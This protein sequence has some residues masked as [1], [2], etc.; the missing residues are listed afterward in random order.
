MCSHDRINVA[1]HCFVFI[2]HPANPTIVKM[3]GDVS[4]DGVHSHST[5][6]D[7]SQSM[8]EVVDPLFDAIAIGSFTR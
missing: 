5:S 6:N 1:S 8:E 2:I 4:Q 3:E 7:V